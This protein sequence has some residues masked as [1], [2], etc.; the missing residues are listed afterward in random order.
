M[1]ENLFTAPHLACH[2]HK[3]THFLWY[4]NLPGQSYW[5]SPQREGCHHRSSPWPQSVHADIQFVCV[6]FFIML[7]SFIQRWTVDS[8][9]PAAL[10]SETIT[11]FGNPSIHFVKGLFHSRHCVG[12]VGK[13][14]VLLITSFKAAKWNRA[15]INFIM[16]TCAFPAVT[17]MRLHGVYRVKGQ[18]Q[19]SITEIYH[20]SEQDWDFC[21]QKN[22]RLN[23][24]SVSA[25]ELNM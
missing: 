20:Q 25:L 7:N 19:W 14:Q 22:L 9:E 18:S 17:C 6:N 1:L 11:T 21:E 15:I 2:L 24:Y 10:Q 4:C 23:L 8:F 12:K 5:F 3:T 16:H 13:A